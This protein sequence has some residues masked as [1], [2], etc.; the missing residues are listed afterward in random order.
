[1]LDQRIKVNGKFLTQN[2]VTFTVEKVVNI[3]IAYG[4][5]LWAYEEDVSFTLRKS[6]FGSV[7]LTK[8]TDF[9]KHKYSGYGIGFDARGIFWLSDNS[10]FGKNVIILVPI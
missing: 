3:Y 4:I 6:L 1:M 7:T 5:N 8:S 9:G 10:S 2:K